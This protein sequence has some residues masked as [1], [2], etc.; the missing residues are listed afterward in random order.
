M[1]SWEDQSLLA[2]Q[3]SGCYMGLRAHRSRVDGVSD[4]THDLC[5]LEPPT[6]ENWLRTFLATTVRRHQLF[7]VDSGDLGC[8]TEHPLE[9]FSLARSTLLLATEQHLVRGFTHNTKQFAPHDGKMKALMSPAV[10]S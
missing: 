8:L 7:G 6:L 9:I 4:P 3:R 2:K 5:G 10:K 1:L